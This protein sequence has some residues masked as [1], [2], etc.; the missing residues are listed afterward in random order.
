MRDINQPQRRDTV[1]VVDDSPETLSLITD[2]LASAGVTVLVALDGRSA[3]TMLDEITP[4]IV[5]MDA[6]MP[7]LD[8][9]ETC[10]LL[11]QR[12]D[13]PV[14]FMTGLCETEHIVR[15]MEVGGVD[16]ITKPVTP[17]ELLARMRVH[18]T[19]ARRTSSARA[20]LDASGRH[21]LAVNAAGAMLWSTPQANRLL[22][23]CLQA[24]RLTVEGTTLT[25]AE[26]LVR[27]LGAESGPPVSVPDAEARIEAQL[28]GQLAEDEFLLSLARK[29]D[30]PP[31]QLLGER[32]GLTQ[33]Q[34]EVLYWVANG[35]ANRD[36]ALILSMSPRTVN[37]H[38]EQIFLKL[39][40]EN[41]TSAAV[42]GLNALEPYVD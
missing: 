23:E 35:K 4:D 15:G 25:L 30:V 42:I 21:M 38:L 26:W 33:R 5:L 12:H 40:V 29:R 20:A 24:E 37:K 16:Y 22:E 8:G 2:A 13:L 31:E 3:L 17:D 32:L 36:I 39:G 6:M 19:N 9:F 34:A 14:I 27:C 28:I 11:K 10:R 18:L 41:R 7:G 1:L